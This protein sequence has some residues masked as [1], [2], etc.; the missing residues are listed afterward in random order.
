M[1]A[2][3]F[4]SPRAFARIQ[5]TWLKDRITDFLTGLAAQG[6]KIQTMRAYAHQLRGFGESVESRGVREPKQLA[7]QVESFVQPIRPPKKQRQWRSFLTRFANFAVPQ[8]I[9]PV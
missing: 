1:T 5:Q 8:A 9:A 4:P 7:C 6:F 3:P 2:R